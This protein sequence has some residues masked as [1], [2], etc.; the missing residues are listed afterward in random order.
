MGAAT[1]H[2]DSS[3]TEQRKRET[4]QK[5][6]S[7]REFKKLLCIFGVVGWTGGTFWLSVGRWQSPRC[8]H[9]VGWAKQQVSGCA[10]DKLVAA[11]QLMMVQWFSSLGP[12]PSRWLGWIRHFQPRSEN[13]PSS[14]QDQ[15]WVWALKNSRDTIR[16]LVYAIGLST[17]KLRLN[18]MK[19][20][21]P[22][23][24]TA[25]K[26]VTWSDLRLKRPFCL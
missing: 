9:L 21:R 22:R 3:T 10:K 13:Q 14:R 15:T 16:I 12:Y 17:A 5:D 25:S 18:L 6:G 7:S 2:S 11:L 24:W 4:T 8:A 20:E 19:K 1:S 26:G 23:N